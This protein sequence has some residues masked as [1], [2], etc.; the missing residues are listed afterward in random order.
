MLGKYLMPGDHAI[1]LL[2]GDHLILTGK[3]VNL[4]MFNVPLKKSILPL[5]YNV[6]NSK[7]WRGNL[8]KYNQGKGVGEVNKNYGRMELKVYWLIIEQ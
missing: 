1:R 2:P 8:E 3:D 7:I 4:I 6:N 5:L